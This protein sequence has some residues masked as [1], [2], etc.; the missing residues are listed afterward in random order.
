MFVPEVTQIVN[1]SILEKRSPVDKLQHLL[2]VSKSTQLICF[3]CKKDWAQSF[4]RSDVF[5]IAL[6]HLG[7]A[8]AVLLFR[9]QP[10]FGSR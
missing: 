2:N 9:S 6:F 7:K 10:P 1:F 5:L 3:A 4:L 8:V